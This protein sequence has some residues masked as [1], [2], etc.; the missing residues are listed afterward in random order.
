MIQ[1]GKIMILR[2]LSLIKFQ[3]YCELDSCVKIYSNLD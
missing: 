2:I 1:Q 3:Q